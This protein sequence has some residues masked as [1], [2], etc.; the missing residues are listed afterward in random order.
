M[1]ANVIDVLM[2]L[3]E[4]Y[5]EEGAEFTPDEETLTDELAQAGFPKGEISKA[6]EWLEGLSLLREEKPTLIKQKYIGAIR[7]FT[8]ME[9]EK[10]DLDCRGFLIFL[11]QCGVLDASTRETVID[12]IM[13]LDVP[14]ITLDQL[15]WV[16]L[17]ILFNHPDMEQAYPFLEDLVLEN[18][19]NKLH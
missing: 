14:E 4:N 18:K 7:H 17:M 19:Q 9:R 3:L 8:P 6:F 11:E 13:A 16:V 5:M 10:I 15:K 2:Y 12:R 1:K